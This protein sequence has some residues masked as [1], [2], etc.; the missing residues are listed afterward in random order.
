[1]LDFIKIKSFFIRKVK[2]QKNFFA[3]NNNQENEKLTQEWR[4]NICKSSI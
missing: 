1:M 2:K 4:K 3:K